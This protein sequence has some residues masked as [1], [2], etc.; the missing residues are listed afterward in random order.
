M[1][2]DASQPHDRVEEFLALPYDCVIRRAAD[3]FVAFSPA[4]PFAR[5]A[6]AEEA[7]DALENSRRDCFRRYVA[8]TA[9]ILGRVAYRTVMA[10]LVEMSKI[11]PERKREIRTTVG[12]AA[13]KIRPIIAEALLGPASDCPR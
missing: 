13:Q 7:L 1:S 2:Q 9:P 12:A 8:A 11:T 4:L 5:G 10:G 6:R 3:G